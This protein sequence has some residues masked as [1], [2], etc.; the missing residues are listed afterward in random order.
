MNFG[1]C[2]DV[3]LEDDPEEP[4]MIK[5]A[6]FDQGYQSSGRRLDLEGVT[7]PRLAIHSL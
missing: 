7:V 1:S 2:R 3:D 6:G 5:I 4:L